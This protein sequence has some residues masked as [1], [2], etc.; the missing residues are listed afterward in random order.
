MT[1]IETGHGETALGAKMASSVMLG[2]HFTWKDLM[3]VN[4]NHEAEQVAPLPPHQ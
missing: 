2:R 1:W 3:F 4:R